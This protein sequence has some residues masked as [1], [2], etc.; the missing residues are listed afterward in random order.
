M[1]VFAKL[2]R[3]RVDDF[4]QLSDAQIALLEE[5]WDLLCR[6]NRVVNLTSVTDLESAVMKHYGESLFLAANL[7]QGGHT[8]ADL[9]SGGGFPGIPIAVVRADYWVTLIECRKRKAAF[10]REATRSLPNVQ[11]L[12]SR[13]EDCTAPF[14]WMVARAVSIE[15]ALS[16]GLRFGSRLGMLLSGR[17]A[18]ELGRRGLVEVEKRLPLPWNCMS[19]LVLGRPV[20]RASR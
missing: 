4:C 13:G 8:L 19:C 6:W 20:P 1:S 12:E 5:H 10:L 18:D 17:D 9:G 15:H 11:V 14:D 16:C 2:L 3:G 7:P